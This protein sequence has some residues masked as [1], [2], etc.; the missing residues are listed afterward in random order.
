LAR[1]AK[2]VDG[3][4]RAIRLSTVSVVWVCGLA[5]GYFG[6][7]GATAKYGCT[8]GADGFG[9]RTSGSIVGIVIVIAVIAIVIAVTTLTI[10]RPRRRVLIVG[11]FGL[12]A[13]AACFTLAQV[14]LATT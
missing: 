1:H 2:T 12:L 6:L 4:L 8:K 13:L 5:A 14:L 9:C 7:L 10:D 11:G 3:R